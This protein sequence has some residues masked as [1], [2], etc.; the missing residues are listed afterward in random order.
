MPRNYKK[1]PKL[2]RL[3]ELFKISEEYPTGLEWLINKAGYKKG[4]C[5]GKINTSNGYY[6]VSI[7]NES[8]MAHRIVYYLRTE[9]CPDNYSVIHSFSNKLKDN[10]LELKP[11][12]YNYVKN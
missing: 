1:M 2:W 5:A 10:R 9:K 7:D 6:F 8:Y 11:A 4:D 12:F 3:K